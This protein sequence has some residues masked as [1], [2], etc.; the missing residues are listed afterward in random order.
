MSMEDLA[1]RHGPTDWQS[2]LSLLRLETGVATGES[3]RMIVLNADIGS[4]TVIMREAIDFRQFGFALSTLF[5]VVSEH[6]RLH[7]GWFDKSTG[8]GFLAY[9]IVDNRHESDYTA[10]VSNTCRRVLQIF[11]NSVEPSLRANSR[12]FPA[13]SGISLGLDAG[14]A[15]L[16]EVAGDLT[17]V[18]PPV[19]G[20]VRMATAAE[21]YETI[22][23]I[24]LASRW[25]QQ[26]SI[27][28]RLALTLSE[29]IRPTKESLSGQVIYKIGGLCGPGAAAG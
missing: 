11:R 22:A 29:E 24:H 25:R 15:G 2:E 16:V 20:S 9:W 26:P 28:D 8:D 18:G 23:N 7:R 4:S 27:L 12:N 10:D 21:P 17:I 14:P 3:V 13:R 5:T 1:N 19:V 6:V